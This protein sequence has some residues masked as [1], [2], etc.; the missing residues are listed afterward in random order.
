MKIFQIATLLIAMSMLISCNNAPAGDKATTAEAA[1]PAAAQ[2]GQSYNVVSGQSTVAWTGSKLTGQ[3]TGTFNVSKGNVTATDGQ[4]TG[5]KFTV[6]I[7][8]MN[9]TDLDGEQKQNIE[10]HLKSGDFFDAVKY[11]TSTFE[12]TK[13][14]PLQ[15]EAGVTHMI[16]GNLQLKDVTKEIGFKANVANNA[17]VLKVNTPDFTINRTDFN[18]KY[19]S[20]SFFDDLKDKAINDEVGLKINLVAKM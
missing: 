16:F 8:S 6:D 14:S 18:M 2:S 10:G 11:P 19:G 20:A 3:H 1:K 13:V 4:I 5:G 9:C 12:I 17:G 15:G 7:A